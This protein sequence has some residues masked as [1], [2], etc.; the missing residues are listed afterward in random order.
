VKHAKVESASLSIEVTLM[1]MGNVKKIGV[2]MMALQ[3]EKGNAMAILH[4]ENV[5]I[6]DT[7]AST[8][9]T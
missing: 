8:H 3:A 2:N 7:V 6:C 5:W 1:S 9:V 4:D